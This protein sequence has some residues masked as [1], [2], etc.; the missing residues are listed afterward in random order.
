M[1]HKIES[2]RNF[3]APIPIKIVRLL[4][5]YTQYTQY[6]IDRQILSQK[7]YYTPT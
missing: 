1:N 7:S 5:Q 2:C 6:T 3:Y 4:N